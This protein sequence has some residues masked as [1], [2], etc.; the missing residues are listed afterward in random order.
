VGCPL[1]QCPPPSLHPVV[2]ACLPNASGWPCSHLSASRQEGGTVGTCCKLWATSHM[3]KLWR[4]LG[5]GS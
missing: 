1:E 4:L 3:A 2:L 5:L